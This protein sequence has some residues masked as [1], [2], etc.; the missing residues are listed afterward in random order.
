M[1]NHFLKAQS[2]LELEVSSFYKGKAWARSQLNGVFHR[3][4]LVLAQSSKLELEKN[5]LVLP[6][7]SE[8]QTKNCFNWNS[9]P[10]LVAQGF[11]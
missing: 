3:L 10:V 8:D 5:G 7:G 1:I 4:R 2:R 6:L 9:Q 11:K